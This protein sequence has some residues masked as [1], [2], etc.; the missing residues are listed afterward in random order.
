MAFDH[1]GVV[2]KSLDIGRSHFARILDVHNWSKEFS[3][4]L[5]GVTV[6]FGRDH[7][8]VCYEIIEPRGQN[9][10]ILRALKDRRSILNHVAYRVHDLTRSAA[11]LR[12]FG[13]A[14]TGPARPA[15]AYNRQKIQFFVTPLNFIL[16]LIEA[17]EHKHQFVFLPSG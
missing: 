5:N 14:P 1:V 12:A 3:D 9:S 4:D 16:E 8:G 2:V 13:C 15:V 10:P 17:P 7:S 6:Q 11:E